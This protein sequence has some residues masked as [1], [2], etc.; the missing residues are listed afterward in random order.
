VI[1]PSVQARDGATEEGGQL[2]KAFHRDVMPGLFDHVER[3]ATK[4]G[5]GG[6]LQPFRDG[7]PDLL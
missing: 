4:F 5:G 6:N 1:R 3:S 7:L 2:V